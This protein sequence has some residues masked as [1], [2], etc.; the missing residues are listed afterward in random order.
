MGKLLNN[1][2]TWF[3][4]KQLSFFILFGYQ[5]KIPM[6]GCSL[7]SMLKGRFG[8]R[9]VLDIYIFGH[10][11]MAREKRWWIFYESNG[12]YRAR[13]LKNMKDSYDYVKK[14]VVFDV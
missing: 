4:D 11:D 6:I 7:L 5:T 3:I 12:D 13:A 10:F 2:V 14:N 1:L 8:F 9:T